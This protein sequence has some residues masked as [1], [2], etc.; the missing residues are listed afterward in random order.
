MA[1][2]NGRFPRDREG[3]EAL[4]GVGQYIANAILLL[5]HGKAQSL[6]DANMARVLERLFGP[7]EL[8]DIR[9]D[10]YLQQLA[11]KVV[12][13]KEA[14]DI[15]WAI[16]DVAATICLISNPRCDECPLIS[17]CLTMRK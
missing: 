5:C 16:L 7:R 14:K 13:C 9:Y 1:K 4:P 2:K 11:L 3:I 10:P 17:M 6:L 15:N 8:A 12:Q